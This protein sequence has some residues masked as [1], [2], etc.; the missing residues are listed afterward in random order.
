MSARL[1]DQVIGEKLQNLPAWRREGDAIV[2][3]VTCR[4]FRHALEVVN[5]VGD[6]A[7]RMDHHPDLLIHRWNRMRIVLS[8]HSAGGLTENDFA[9]AQEIESLLLQMGI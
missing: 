2:R 9:L 1:S 4:D 7:E 3:D 8:T 6:L 5:C